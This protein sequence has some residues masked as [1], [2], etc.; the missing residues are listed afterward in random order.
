MLRWSVFSTYTKI[1]GKGYI[2]VFRGHLKAICFSVQYCHLEVLDQGLTPSGRSA[3]THSFHHG[4][5]CQIWSIG[6]EVTLRQRP[7]QRHAYKLVDSR[8]SWKNSR[9]FFKNS[10]F[11]QLWVGD[12]TDKRPKTPGV[13]Y[14]YEKAC[15]VY[16]YEEALIQS[17]FVFQRAMTPWNLLW[18]WLTGG[19]Y[20][21]KTPSAP[22]ASSSTSSTSSWRSWQKSTP[23]S[24][25][26]FSRTTAWK[27]SS[28]HSSGT[29]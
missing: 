21:R 6:L 3:R 22:W 29:L 18:V 7:N 19:W 14:P 10:R 28:N 12:H 9:N 20:P 15:K 5:I 1:T 11:R 17:L 13:T 16:A 4:V 27:R 24:T 2:A 26:T 23:P 8:Y 25:E